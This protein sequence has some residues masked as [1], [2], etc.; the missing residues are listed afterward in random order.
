MVVAVAVF[1]VGNDSLLFSGRLVSLF[2]VVVAVVVPSLVPHRSNEPT[3]GPRWSFLLYRR[4]RRCN[5]NAVVVVANVPT[6]LFLLRFG[7]PNSRY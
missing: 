6:L 3:Q 7:A 4:R 1:V 5:S 2:Y